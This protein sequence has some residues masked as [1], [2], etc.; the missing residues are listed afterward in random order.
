MLI[1][2]NHHVIVPD[3]VD[4]AFVANAMMCSQSDT[5]HIE[6]YGDSII[7]GRDPDRDPP[8]GGVCN[9]DMTTGRVPMPPAALLEE[10]LPQ[11]RLNI[12]TRSVG[13]T[14]SEQ[15]LN[16]TD[17][18]NGVWPDDIAANVVVVNHGL[19]DARL[20]VTVNQYKS[21]LLALRQR[22]P[23]GIKMV[24]LAPAP[25]RFWDTSAYATAMREV[26][27]TYGDPVADA[28][29]ISQWVDKLFDGI[30]PRQIGYAELVE[31]ALSPAVN[32]GIVNYLNERGGNFVYRKNYIDKFTL[33]NQNQ[34]QLP[35]VPKS[36]SWV[37]VY[38]KDTYLY[39]VAS[40]GA[41]DV[42][43][44]SSAGVF[45]HNINVPLWLSTAGYNLSKIR[46]DTG[47]TVFHK[48]Y[49][50]TVSADQ[51]RLLADELN[52][53]SNEYV[54]ILTTFADASANRLTPELLEAMLRCGASTSIYGNSE[55]RAGSAYILVGVPGTGAGAG[56]EAY[57]GD[58]TDAVDSYAEI[59]FE[60]TP[61][62][63]PA[64]KD[65]FPAVAE[66]VNEITANVT[67][68]VNPMY[69]IVSNA[70]P[71]NG[72]RVLNAQYTTYRTQGIPN[73][74]F[75]VVGNTII[76]TSNVTGSYTVITDTDA[77]TPRG[78]LTIPVN[79]IQSLDLYT[80]RFNATRWAPGRPNVVV[81]TG[82]VTSMSPPVV[83]GASG[84]NALGI[85]NTK[86]TNRVGD[87]LHA[88]PVVITQ[89]QHGTVKL[90]P[91]R[92]SLVYIP[93]PDFVGLDTF[94]YTLVTQRG[95]SAPPHCI[96][97]EVV[98]Q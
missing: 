69:N 20:S 12:T 70:A 3:I 63:Y 39:R 50:T 84:V 18:V 43:S 33:V 57:S 66:V 6:L 52:R 90:S 83:E 96:Y 81:S 31:L 29:Q 19:N 8:T 41:A 60:M 10:F 37:E 16:G 85:Y 80:Y 76:F 30:H 24:W 51:A 9:G 58:T 44:L 88:A 56:H 87:A 82:N 93:F 13:G 98:N 14:T 86:I 55:F 92:R 62:G 67:Y 54:V 72:F 79:N 7:C 42:F 35:Y 59:L 74:V 40:R 65:I 53:T 36:A 73:E 22:L 25:N 5:V 46:R 89:P 91:D 23:A 48:N 21:N 97:I 68:L 64:I 17:G 49:D 1:V 75:N 47:K 45:E 27:A 77:S 61:A 4:L 28:R 15:L 11:Y 78:A 94:S 38:L 71:V 95:Q 32:A 34:I 26:A 2:G